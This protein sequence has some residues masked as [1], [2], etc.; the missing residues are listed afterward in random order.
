MPLKYSSRSSSSNPTSRELEV[1]IYSQTP[2]HSRYPLHGSLTSDYSGSG[3]T[4]PA[5]GGLLALFYPALQKGELRV[6]RRQ[7]ECLL[8]VGSGSGS[9]LKA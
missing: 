3:K 6:R 1:V 8:E 5:A 4:T 7:A 2:K 9:V